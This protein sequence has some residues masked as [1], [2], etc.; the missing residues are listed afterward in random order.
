MRLGTWGLLINTLTTHI[1]K[2][3][4]VQSGITRYDAWEIGANCG[5]SYLGQMEF[6]TICQSRGQVC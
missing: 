1:K 6:K 5:Q 3:I 2:V 4:I